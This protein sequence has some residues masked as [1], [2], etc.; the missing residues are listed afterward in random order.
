V[1][2][3]YALGIRYGNQSTWWEYFAADSFGGT[4]YSNTAI[5]FVGYTSE[6]W[7]GLQCVNNSNYAE[8]WARGWT[9]AEAAWAS[10]RTDKFLFVGD[11][12]VVR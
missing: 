2:S 9:T 5:C 4:D 8:F 12:L 6:P 1:S 11:P 10:A 3:E 7:P